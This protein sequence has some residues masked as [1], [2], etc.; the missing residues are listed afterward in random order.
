MIVGNTLLMDTHLS[1]AACSSSGLKFDMAA[2]PTA[3]DED[4]IPS[5]ILVRYLSSCCHA[6]KSS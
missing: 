3:T 6:E 4:D 5:E 2:Y 1:C